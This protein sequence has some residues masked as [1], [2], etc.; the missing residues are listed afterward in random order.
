MKHFPHTYVIVFAIIVA[1]A[2]LTWIIP[3]GEFERKTIVANGHERVVIDAQ[4][5]KY[6][7]NQPQIWEIFGAFFQGFVNQAGIIVFILIIGGTFWV[8]N[9][10]QSIDVGIQALV[11]KIHAA[12]QLKM[13]R[14]LGSDNVA[15]VFI[16]LIFSLF[17]AVFGMSE[18]TIA[19]IV[20][21]VPL[22]IS[23]GY[24][25]IVGISMTYL[26]AHVGFAAAMMNPFTIGIAQG[27]AQLPLFSGIEY[28]FICWL[29]INSIAIAFVLWYAHRIK[30]NPQRSPM[31]ELD[32]SWR[33]NHSASMD[34]S[35]LRATAKSWI[36]YILLVL[37]GIYL[38]FSFSKT[39]IQIGNSLLSFNFIAII[40]AYF[41]ISSFWAIR[42]SLRYFIL[43][44]LITTIFILI[45]GVLGYEWYIKEIA[46]LFLGLGI[47]TA[48]VFG[49]SANETVKQFLDGAKDIL[50]A[51][52]VVGLA[53]GI[54][55]LLN[56]GKIIDTILYHIAQSLKNT[57]EIG[58]VSM[59]YLFQ[60][61]LN[62][63]IP[64]GS[65]KAA[66]TMP[67]MAQFSDLI[68]ISRQLTVLAF[69]FGDGFTNMITPTS[70]V[71]LGAL[72][73]A[74]IPYTIWFKWILPFILLLILIG[75]FLLLP[76]MYWSFNGF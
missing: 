44:L 2:A 54:I 75:W 10:T 55:V 11:K 73:M 13:I 35:H 69:Q 39:T 71:L 24:D 28:R 63:I 21:F 36:V 72:S 6:V 66:L 12:N 25:S 41:S 38:S 7:P 32:K 19:F 29:I 23:M 61:G 37:T 74:K 22:A 34:I 17:G 16:M 4:S 33:N 64:S 62:I 56:D 18:E 58:S 20:I 59:M 60:N 3:G 57:G 52:L 53:G 26:A 31:Y 49:Y 14:I 8:I 50:S 45:L 27:I 1:V 68:G 46:S 65:A 9:S 51:A 47:T 40:T 43:N 67:I 15:I 48:I 30:K 42:K 70:G 76:P 5:F